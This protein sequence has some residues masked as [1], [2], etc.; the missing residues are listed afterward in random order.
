[1]TALVRLATVLWVGVIATFIVVP[2]LPGSIAGPLPQTI[3]SLARTVSFQQRWGMY[4]PNPQRAQV[5]M[6]LTAVYADGRKE[7]LEETIDTREGWG[8]HWFWDKNRVDIWRF[9]ANY[10]P[11]KRNDNR[12]WYLRGVCVREARRGEIPDKIV[13]YH[14][15]RRFAPPDK[16]RQGALGLGRPVRKLVTVQYC[17]TKQ[18]LEMIER[19]RE[20]RG[21]PRG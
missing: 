7:E 11:D 18:V 19:D 6:D 3:G 9:Y 5:Y 20:R 15:R 12:T 10:H 2:A 4:A 21:G 8:T 1:M 14:V 17:K 16:V 13:M